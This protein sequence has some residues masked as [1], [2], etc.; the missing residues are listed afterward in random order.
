[1]SAPPSRG[2]S[3]WPLLVF[4]AA[5]LGVL[6]WFFGDRLLEMWR[7]WR[8]ES[9]PLPEPRQRVQLTLPPV[10]PTDWPQWRGPHRDGISAEK[11]LLPVWPAGGPKLLWT[12]E[13]LGAGYSAPAVVGGKVF[14][15]G[16]RDDVEYLFVLDSQTGQVEGEA[17]LG[18]R[19]PNNWGDGPRGTPTLDGNRLYA[20]S[21]SGDLMCLDLT[22]GNALWRKRIY[23][24]FGGQMP[25]WGCGESPLVDGDRVLCT[26]GGP[27]GTVVALHKMTGDLLWQS[28]GLTDLAGYS[29]LIPAEIGGVRQ[30]VQMTFHHVVGLAANDGRLLWK[31]A[32]EGPNAPVPTPIIHNDHVYV[33]SGYGA[34]CHLIKITRQGETFTAEQVYASKN[35]SNHH[36]GVVRLGEHL[37][38][39]AD[40]RGWVCQHLLTGELLWR[41]R[42]KLSKG[43]ITAADGK[44][45]CYGEEDGTLVVIE[46]SSQGWQEKGRF[47]IPRQS[48]LPRRSGGIW[49]HPVIA[50]GKLYLRDQELLFCYQLR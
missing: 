4:C 50:D 12:A 46:A 25:Q 5:V 20:L 7:Q 24:D 47:T 35:L 38:G 30:Y 18:H 41:E 3:R 34:G 49:T 28:T 43:S 14:L 42:R 40:N 15:P 39:Y 9:S 27:R 16:T 21:G 37:F 8:R 17:A 36:G 1:M 31:F 44:L 10:Q 26:P 19:F 6:A 23:Q 29:S 13:N 32:R 45:F 2:R 11:G 33:T 48:A 22:T